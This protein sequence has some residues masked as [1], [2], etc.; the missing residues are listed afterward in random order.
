MY[1]YGPRLQLSSLG[2]PVGMCADT[3]I[4]EFNLCENV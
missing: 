4:D 1:W 3:Q 2:W